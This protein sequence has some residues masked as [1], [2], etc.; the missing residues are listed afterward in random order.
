MID[1][2]V[3]F[4]ILALTL[5]Y[6]VIKERQ[7]LGCYKISI[8]RQCDDANSVYIQ[9]TK[10]TNVDS[11]EELILRMTSIISYHEKGAVWRRCFIIA[12]IIV[13]FV[14]IMNM[15]SKC[16]NV[17]HYSIILLM[18]LTI[19]Y[20]YHNYINYHHFRN[21][22]QNGVEILERMKKNCFKH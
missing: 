16:K 7:E 8:D 2:C 15:N 10:M 19:I 5:F 3:I 20:F 17:Y 18:T 11:C 9:N 6:A 13:V 14:Y 21:L 22:K 1:V 12:V 4:I